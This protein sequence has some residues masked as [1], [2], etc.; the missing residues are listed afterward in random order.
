VNQP[1]VLAQ[2]CNIFWKY[3]ISIAAVI[4]KEPVSSKFV[5]IVLTTYLAKEG[6]LQAAVEQVDKLDVVRAKTKIIRILK[7]DT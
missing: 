3:N 4:Q 7:A 2:I 1:G 5:P 6:A